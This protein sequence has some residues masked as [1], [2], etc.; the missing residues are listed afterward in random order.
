MPRKSSAAL[1]VIEPR[2]YRPA[3]PEGLS[4]AERVAF[5]AAVCS[6]RPGHFAAEE[7]P[8]LVAFAS[9]T[10]QER[11]IAQELDAAET[12]TAKAALWAAHGRAAGDAGR[13]CR[14]PW[15]LGAYGAGTPAAAVDGLERS[16]RLARAASCLGNM[17][18]TTNRAG[19]SIDAGGAEYPLV[20]GSPPPAPEGRFVGQR[21]E[22]APFM[23][24]DFRAIYDNPHG[25]RRAIISRGRKN[26]KTCECAF[27]LLLHLC[28]PEHRINSQ[29]FSCQR[30]HA[31]QAAVLFS[32]AAKIVRLSP[33]L[34]NVIVIAIH[35]EKS[36]SVLSSERAIRR[37]APRSRPP[38]A[39]RPALEAIFDEL[40]QAR[41]PQDRPC[42]RPLET[43]TA[44]F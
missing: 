24:D 3:P 31:I 1:K 28:G 16:R 11:A 13:G 25:T 9:A 44:A 26:S 15:R 30:S 23:K 29:M 18:P 42:T 12:L 34:Q 2:G 33:K 35:G 43:A 36:F 40:G 19:G 5:T 7:V 21:L 17:N 6:V 27:I 22:M 38:T 4:E 37:S 41:G 10:V 8:L 39:F 14:G 20:R 32:L